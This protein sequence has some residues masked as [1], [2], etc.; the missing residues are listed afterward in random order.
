MVDNVGRAVLAGF[1]L[2]DFVP[3]QSASPSS[4]AEGGAVRWI[5][6][7]LSPEEYDIS[8]LHPTKESDCYALGMVVYEILSGSPPFG[9][10]SPAIHRT[11]LERKRPRRPEGDAAKLFTD[12]IWTVV[13]RCWAERPTERPSARDVLWC[14]G[15]DP[16]IEC[17]AD[18]LP[19]AALGDLEYVC[20]I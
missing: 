20:F 12:T 10:R 5:N 1:T 15:G 13:E 4:H 11:V 6:P 17:D 14:L 7:E 18:D 2:L 3:D 19:D 16:G 8:E 9:R